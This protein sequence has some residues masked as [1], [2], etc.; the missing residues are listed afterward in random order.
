MHFKRACTIRISRD[1]LITNKAR[2]LLRKSELNA[3]PR[4]LLGPETHDD[5]SDMEDEAVNPYNNIPPEE[6]IVILAKAAFICEAREAEG[7]HNESNKGVILRL[8]CMQQDIRWEIYGAKQAK[9]HQTTISD[10]FHS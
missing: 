3:N 7:L 2:E 9:M 4:K 6:Q 10:Y 5:Q 1:G 8:T